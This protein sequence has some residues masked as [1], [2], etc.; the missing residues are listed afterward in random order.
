MHLLQ[1]SLNRGEI[2][3]LAHARR[4]LKLYTSAAAIIENWFVLRYGGI[5]R[6]SGT[7]YVGAAKY[8]DKKVAFTD[9]VFNNGQ[10]FVLEWGHQYLRFWTNGGQIVS[11]MSPYEIVTPYTEDEVEDIQFAVS[12]DLIYLAHPN[13]PPQ[14]LQR[15]SNTNWTIGDVVFRDGPYMPINDIITSTVTPSGNLLTGA[16]LTFT[17]TAGTAWVSGDVGRQ[18]RLK[19]DGKWAFCVITAVTS[20]LIVTATVTYGDNQ[21]AAASPSWQLG[22]FGTVPGYPACVTFYQQRLVWARTTA[23]PRALFC[24]VT[25]V[26]ER[27]SPSNTDGTTTDEDGFTRDITSGQ[28][29]PILW[30]KEGTRIIVGTAS[31]IRSVGATSDAGQIMTARNVDTKIEKRIGSHD[32]M[33]ADAD[34]GFCFAGRSG[35]SVR[36]LTEDEYGKITCPDISVLAEHL[37]KAKIRRMAH[38]KTPDGI[39]WCITDTGGL[40][41]ITIDRDESVTGWHNHPTTG[42]VESLAVIPTDDRDELW[43]LVRRTINGGT[44]RY[45]EILEAPFDEDLHDQ[46]DAFFVDCG[47]T[48]EGS[49]VNVVSGL[50][51]LAGAV[52]DVY[53]EGSPLPRI[54]VSV[55]GQATLPNG[56]TTTKC[57]FGLPI[58]NRVVTLPAPTVAPDG[59]TLGRKTKAISAVLSVVSTLG[60]VIGAL[61]RHSQQLKYRSANTP[62]GSAPPLY[63]G[64]A[65]SSVDDTWEGRGQI[66]FSC[67]QPTPATI[68][69]FNLHVDS[70]P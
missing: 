9:Y 51:H 37:C 13:H 49:A 23:M 21:V 46:D 62:M 61:G 6:R 68:I 17:W 40:F 47:A 56:K 67:P 11:G 32:V 38:Q 52:V 3:P 22:A 8:A 53:S 70:E 1:A 66:E 35:L 55:G 24:S 5:R 15:L 41:G 65:T 36:N 50:G 7:R 39:V 18:F 58:P 29:D 42:F 63:T 31:A 60:V 25:S 43:L 69:A 4:D 16:S 44:V 10:A 28:A 2:T 12:G 19:V 14:K 30:L 27:Y 34:Q 33:P 20:G 64:E 45:V 54:T 59:S 57:H 48:Y 26:P